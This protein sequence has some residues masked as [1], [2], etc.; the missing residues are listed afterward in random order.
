MSVAL[1]AGDKENS[2]LSPSPKELAIGIPAVITTI[3]LEGKAIAWV[4]EV[5]PICES[6]FS[7]IKKIDS[8][9]SSHSF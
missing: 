6:V 2:A 9:I 8:S 7:R 4:E 5:I 1:P 3:D